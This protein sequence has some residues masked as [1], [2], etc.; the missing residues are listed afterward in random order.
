MIL[1]CKGIVLYVAKTKALISCMVTVQLICALK[2]FYFC[3]C[4]MQVFSW[5]GSSLVLLRHTVKFLNFRTPKSF[6]VI[7]LKF[8]Q[9]SPNLRVFCEKDAN[10]IAYSED[11]DQTAPLGAV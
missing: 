1:G 2:P 5:C 9:K 3:I 4:N 6:A 7:N 8:K 11:P 10:G